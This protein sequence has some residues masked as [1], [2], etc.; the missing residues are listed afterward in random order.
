MKKWF[1]ILFATVCAVAVAVMVCMTVSCTYDE[2]DNPDPKVRILFQPEMFM[3]MSHNDVDKYP[4]ESTF[5]VC[6]WELPA[7]TSWQLGYKDA[8][9]YLPLSEARSS[10][11]FITDT[12][13]RDTVKDTLWVISDKTAWPQEKTNHLF[14]AFSPFK[15][16][17]TCTIEDGVTYVTDI[18]ENQT[19]LLYT[20]PLTNKQKIRDG[21]L[22]PIIF[23]HALCRVEFKAKSRVAKGEKI[24]LKSVK[25]NRIHHKGVFK[26]LPH[27]YWK[28]EVSFTELPIFEGNEVLANTPEI[29][30]RYW[31]VIPQTLDTKVTVE[32]TFTTVDGTEIN[33]T[34]ETVPLKTMLKEGHKYTMTLSLGMDDVQFMKEIIEN[35]I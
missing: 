11:V 7:N 31:L 16:N 22:V 26:S 23:E 19:D 8:V 6:A 34:L 13:L 3:H 20:A 12:T 10:E 27:P 2:L 5:A 32:Y 17:C 4:T 18:L 1:N 30:G 25:I 14:M 29:I 21:W 28:Q 33:H 15:A 9:E 24:T 35:R